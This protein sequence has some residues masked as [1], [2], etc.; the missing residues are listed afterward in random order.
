MM[1]FSVKCQGFVL[2]LI[3]SKSLK[4]SSSLHYLLALSISSLLH[5]DVNTNCVK[6]IIV[7]AAAN[8]IPN[9]IDVLVV[10][11]RNTP[12]LADLDKDE[13]ADLML[14]AQK[15]GKVVEKH[16]GCTSLTMTIQDGPQAGQTVPHVHMHIIPRKK[17]DWANNDDIYQELDKKQGLDN[18]GR[19]PRTEQEMSLEANELRLYFSLD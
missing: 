5:Q 17:G 2:V 16:Y 1:P 8:K 14:S 11:K 9:T 12:R 18:E 7:I 6:D 10:P 13:T 4:S 15:I 3:S 19:K